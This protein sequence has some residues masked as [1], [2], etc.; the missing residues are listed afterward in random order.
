[1]EFGGK[2]PFLGDILPLLRGFWKN[3]VFLIFWPLSHQR[4]SSQNK[5]FLVEYKP[6]TPPPPVLRSIVVTN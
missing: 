6:M 4:E 1:M 3:F 2:L 5:N